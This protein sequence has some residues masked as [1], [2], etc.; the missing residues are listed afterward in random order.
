MI[1]VAYIAHACCSYTA[2]NFGVSFVVLIKQSENFYKFLF[3]TNRLQF[4]TY[5]PIEFTRSIA[6]RLSSSRRP[7]TNKLKCQLKIE[8]LKSYIAKAWELRSS[9]TN[10]WLLI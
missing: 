9:G 3:T 5:R 10:S 6:T 1:A 8:S 4:I 2:F 7:C